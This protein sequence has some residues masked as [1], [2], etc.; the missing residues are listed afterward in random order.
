MKSRHWLW[1][2]LVPLLVAGWWRLRL[3]V[4]VLDLL[5]K[6]F[7][8]AQGLKLYQT[9]FANAR[10][11]MLTVRASDPAQA[12][13]ATRALGLALRAATNLTT[14]VAWQPPWQE[15]PAE[16]AELIAWHWLNQPPEIFGTLTN[17]L[18]ATNLP[19][20]LQDARDA[21]A[22]SLSPADLARRGYDPFNLT[23]L[24]DSV[25]GGNAF[26]EGQDFFT[27]ADGTFRVLFVQAR[28]DIKKYRDCAGW[29]KSIQTVEQSLRAN[30]DIPADTVIR[31]TGRPAFVTEIA[32]GMEADLISSVASTLLVIVLLFYWAH[33]RLRPLLWLLTLLF[34][35]LVGTLA[36]GGLIFGTLSVISVGFAAILLGLAVDYGMVLYQEALCAPHLSATQLRR[37]LAP[38]IIWSAV[39]TAGAFALLNFGGLPGLAQLGSLVAIGVSLAGLVM[40]LAFLPPLLRSRNGISAV[41]AA[42]AVARDFIGSPRRAWTATAL[43]L[44]I[45]AVVLARHR[46]G[47]DNSAQSLRPKKSEAMTTVEEITT[48]LKR[49]QEPMWMLASGRDEAEVAQRLDLAGAALSRAVSNG[50]IANFKLPSALWP[51][52]G[53]QSANRP[54]VALLVAQEETWRHAALTAGFTSNAFLLTENMLATWRAALAGTNV[55]WPTNATSGWIMDKAVAHPPGQFLALGLIYSAT[56]RLADGSRP[57]MLGVAG[58]LATQGVYVSGWETL[59]HAIFDRVKKD[60]WKVLGPM[61]V[62]L[63]VSL[64][65]AF[66]NVTEVLLSLATLAFSGVA[67]WAIMSLAGWSWNLLNLMALPLLLGSGV[68]YS[69]HMQLALR[70]HR[71]DLAITRR[72]VGRALLLCAGTT[73]AGFGSNAWSSNAGLMSLGLVCATGITCAYLTANYLLPIWWHQLAAKKVL[74]ATR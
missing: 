52:P 28:P 56:N 65:F 73:V 4:E 44:V 16:S 70:R 58:E 43:V 62:L 67:L 8:A 5:P 35:I 19:A 60:F 7:P 64:W 63:L 47:F 57:S 46:P 69:I 42:P 30:N 2:L 34:L 3:N 49:T 41:P 6:N 54:A 53:F 37:E 1:L 25:Q 36:L 61:I 20:V 55:Y 51:K 31:Y 24:P 22:G 13:T 12:E 9:N 48:R 23:Q 26:G 74:S 38:S 40:L 15:R 50:L 68:D 72:S 66:R 33:R 29:L 59:G 11:L 27:S 18:A 17:R 39:T 32:L 21:L 14:S 71:G 45:T 10:E